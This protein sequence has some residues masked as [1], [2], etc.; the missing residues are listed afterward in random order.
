LRPIYKDL[1]LV[2]WH[3]S[4]TGSIEQILT[5]NLDEAN[6]ITYEPKRLRDILMRRLLRKVK[7]SVHLIT[8]DGVY[9]KVKKEWRKLE[10]C[11]SYDGGNRYLLMMYGLGES[12][13]TEAALI[14]REEIR[15]VIL[16]FSRKECDN[17]VITEIDYWG[18]Y[19]IDKYGERDS[20]LNIGST[21]IAHEDPSFIKAPSYKVSNPLAHYKTY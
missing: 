7:Y 21:S 18:V 12:D 14:N 20:K 4:I 16:W 1:Y 17:I 8:A 15:E 10:E 9:T 2:T 5:D 13:K 11:D 3:N 19:T 6:N